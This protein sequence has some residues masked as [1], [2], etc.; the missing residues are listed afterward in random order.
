MQEENYQFVH[1][2]LTLYFTRLARLNQIRHQSRGYIEL[3]LEL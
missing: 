3:H 1:S 2:D